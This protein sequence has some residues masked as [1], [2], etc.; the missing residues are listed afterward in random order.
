MNKNISIN[1][2]YMI[3]VFQHI[4]KQKE[5]NGLTLNPLTVI[6]LVYRNSGG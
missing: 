2:D 4:F 3:L 1:D 6:E 5:E